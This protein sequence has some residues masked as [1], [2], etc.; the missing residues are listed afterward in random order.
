MLS[1]V[2]AFVQYFRARVSSEE[3]AT[4]VEYGIMV[5]LIA[6]ISVLVVGAL[7]LDVFGAFDTA[8]TEIDSG[9]GPLDPS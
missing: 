4:M 8:Q 5:A 2:T 7:G 9:G 3:G 6:V 1:Q